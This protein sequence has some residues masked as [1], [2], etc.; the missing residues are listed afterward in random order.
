[1]QGQI[2][3]A[4]CFAGGGGDADGVLRAGYKPIWAIES[5]RNAAAVF[6]RRFPKCQVIEADIRELPDDFFS[7]LPVPSLYLFG[8]P[9]P[10][11]STAGPRHGLE[12]LRGSLFYQGLRPLRLLK[13]PHFI[14]ENVEG[15]LSSSS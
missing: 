12:G 7:P 5:A 4:H 8:S 13:I 10:D 6:R 2:T 11:F 15:I 1:M 14:F 9:C 3:T